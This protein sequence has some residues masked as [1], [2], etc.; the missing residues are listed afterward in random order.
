MIGR[1]AAPVSADKV[2]GS[3]RE[4]GLVVGSPVQRAPKRLDLQQRAW[5]TNQISHSLPMGNERRDGTVL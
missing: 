1:A 4:C 5:L 2:A 3:K